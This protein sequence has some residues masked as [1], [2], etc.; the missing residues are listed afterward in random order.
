M[1]VHAPSRVHASGALRRV[2]TSLT[3]GPALVYVLLVPAVLALLALV[4]GPLIY[5]VV[6]SLFSWRLTQI[7]QPKNFVG[8]ANYVRILDDTGFLTALANTVIF[9]ISSVVLELLVG[10]AVALALFYM[11]RGRDLAN[12][13]I[14]LPMIIA[15]AIVSLVWRYVLDPQFGLAN[16]LLAMI[17][18][19]GDVAWL[20]TPTLALPS[21]VAIDVWEWTAFPIL[22]FHAATLGVSLDLLEAA[23]ADGAALWGEIRHVILP[24]LK[25]VFVVILLFRTMDAFRIFDTIFLLTQGGPGLAT[26]TLGVYAYRNAFRHFEMGYGMA[27]S[28]VMLLIIVAISVFYLR[29]LRERRHA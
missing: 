28:V 11:G 25:P 9:T 5:S 13:I 17:G 23:R 15:P 20:G 1:Q 19:P 8:L 2:R 27:L 10:L 12:A 6:L 29:V 24:A 16:G 22:V 7:D 26:E 18:L 3:D 4:I 21:I 14:F